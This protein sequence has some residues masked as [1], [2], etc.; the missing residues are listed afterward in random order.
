MYFPN[1]YCSGERGKE[2]GL[3]WLEGGGR[4]V[5]TVVWAGLGGST[6][7]RNKTDGLSGCYNYLQTTGQPSIKYP[8][9]TSVTT[10][11]T[12]QSLRLI[13]YCLARLVLVK[14]V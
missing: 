6:I 2:G 1:I 13:K 9:G 3:E 8:V 5:I 14:Y 7:A 11:Q 10:K 4:T 12:I